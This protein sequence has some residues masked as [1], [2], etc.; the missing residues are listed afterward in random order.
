MFKYYPDPP[1]FPRPGTQEWLERNF[2]EKGI[3][4]FTYM[5]S[6]SSDEYFIRVGTQLGRIP[7][8]VIRKQNT[9]K[10]VEEIERF[11]LGWP[12]REEQEIDM[13]VNETYPDGKYRW[14]FDEFYQDT[15]A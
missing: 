14:N 15:S 7:G 8:G 10:L 3:D 12:E 2:K 1:Y 9:E 4:G 6:P 11:F 13:P 5:R